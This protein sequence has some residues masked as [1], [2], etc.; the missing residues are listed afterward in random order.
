MFISLFVIPSFAQAHP[1]D[2]LGNVKVYD[3]K[4]ILTIDKK[5]TE[6]KIE[7]QF[8]AYEKTLVWESIDTNKDREISSDEKN[9]WMELGKDSSWIVFNGKKYNFEPK[10]VILSDYYTFFSPP[11]TRITLIYTKNISLPQKGSLDYFYNGRDKKITEIQLEI[12]GSNNLTPL[13]TKKIP[14]DRVS[15]IFGK[16][17]TLR[18]DESINPLLEGGSLKTGDRLQNFLNRYIKPTEEIPLSLKLWAIAIA[19]SIGALH[20]LTP[21]HGKGITASFLIGERGT[22]LQALYL[23]LIIT[24]THTSSVFLLGLGALLLTQYIVP[25]TVIRWLNFF[26][27]LLVL[28]FG[29]YLIYIRSKKIPFFSTLRVGKSINALPEGVHSHNHEHLSLKT[30]L[31]LGISGGIVPC[32]DALAIL[33]VAVSLNKILFGIILLLS[34]SLGLASVLIA[35]GIL[36]VVAK[37]KAAKKFRN[38][39]RIEPYLSLTSAIIVT[40]LGIALLLAF[41]K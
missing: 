16:V 13:S 34:F 6:L 19:F 37:N 1:L 5:L 33:I 14:P 26:S 18:V 7:M 12:K 41:L 28:G 20:A 3:E 11:P 35:G 40:V 32:V 39:S 23:G 10:Q 27:G 29:L 25:D 38:I 21:G 22:L 31:P 17:S 2:E 36:V 30:L 9:N 15:V 24:I 4:Q 8:F